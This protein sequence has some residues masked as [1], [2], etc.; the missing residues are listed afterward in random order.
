MIE[1]EKQYLD[2]KSEKPLNYFSGIIKKGWPLEKNMR[3]FFKSESTDIKLLE[4]AKSKEF[5]GSVSIVKF[6]FHVE[7]Y[8]TNILSRS[9]KTLKKNKSFNLKKQILEIQ[10]SVNCG[11]FFIGCV[12]KQV[13]GG[14]TVDLG[15]LLCFMPYSLSDGSRFLPYNPRVNTTQLFQSYGLSLVMTTEEEFFLNLIVSRKNNV[16]L[17]KGLL[18]KYLEKDLTSIKYKKLLYPISAKSKKMKTQ[19]KVISS[20]NMRVKESKVIS[21]KE[22]LHPSGICHTA[23][24]KRGSLNKLNRTRTCNFAVMSGTL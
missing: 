9:N 16:K 7:K 13:K 8:N 20:F 14:F 18:K 1:L 2:F 3:Y 11:N 12:L 15:G 17:L 19:L 22:S 21:V 10:K 4:R 23:R 24:C 5:H 6:L